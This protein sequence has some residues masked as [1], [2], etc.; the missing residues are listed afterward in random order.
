[1]LLFNIC[2]YI[3]PLQNRF[4][5]PIGHNLTIQLL[6]KDFKTL[7]KS[8]HPQLLVSNAQFT[9]RPKQKLS[10]NRRKP[11]HILTYGYIPQGVIFVLLWQLW[12]ITVKGTRN[13]NDTTYILYE[14]S[15]KM[16]YI[17]GSDP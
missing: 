17:W 2:Y 15:I 9:I 6:K 14:I 10:P 4:F 5:K 7:A 16:G 11:L 1:M 8:I 13:A 12:P 3:A